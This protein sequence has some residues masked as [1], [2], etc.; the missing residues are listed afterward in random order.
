VENPL[1]HLNFYNTKNIILIFN[2]IYQNTMPVRL[3]SVVEDV[4]FVNALIKKHG[5]KQE[6]EKSVALTDTMTM[7]TPDM[8][9][10]TNNP[11]G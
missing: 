7:A 5:N 8:S 3:K 1:L 2:S 6:E 10:S 9:I 4:M 11:D